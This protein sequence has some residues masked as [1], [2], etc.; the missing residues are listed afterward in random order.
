MKPAAD[1]PAAKS[2][3]GSKNSAMA[4][5]RWRPLRSRSSGAALLIFLILLVTAALT[6]VVNSLT[7][8]MIEARRAQKTSAA[9]IKA[10]EAIIAWSA[11]NPTLPGRLPCPENASLIGTAT[12]GQAL[13]ACNTL[14]PP[15]TWIGRLPWRT[16]G[17]GE[18]RDGYGE[19]LWYALSDGFRNPPINTNTAAQLIFDSTPNIVAII[20]SSGP[21]LPGQSR[22][23]VSATLPPI[24][25]NYLD[26]SNADGNTSFVST[27]NSATFNDKLLPISQQDLFL[28]VGRRVANEM[29]GDASNG[30]QRYFL[31]NANT[32]PLAANTPLASQGTNSVGYIP[33]GDLMYPG[34]A[35]LNTNAWFPLATYQRNTG[36]QATVTIGTKTYAFTFP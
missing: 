4:R 35:W 2:G 10:K 16:L 32:L 28:A 31:N 20:F 5:R 36:N 27:G 26:L 29:R 21:P 18:L 6:Y 22:P 17:I 15:G 19:P 1:W 34:S 11:T 23:A 3:S 24:V 7:P 12:E 14:P 8:E 30:L 9:L 25:S 13:S 33:Y